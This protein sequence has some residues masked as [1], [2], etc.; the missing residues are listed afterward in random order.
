M[1]T[2]LV[3]CPYDGEAEDDA[4]RIA[5]SSPEGAAKEWARL[6]DAEGDYRIVRGMCAEVYV[7]DGSVVRKILV[8]GEP[9]PVYYARE[10]E[11]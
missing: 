2:Y 5:A 10:L 6:D 4:T 11:W 3:W 1:N 8:S 9:A 7:R